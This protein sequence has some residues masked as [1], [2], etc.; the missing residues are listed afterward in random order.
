MLC[1]IYECE[2]QDRAWGHRKDAVHKVV[3]RVTN[4]QCPS[5]WGGGAGGK[6]HMQTIWI[7]KNP[8]L[9]K[10]RDEKIL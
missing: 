1:V 8:K 4:W 7:L 2:N 9:K 5:A 10:K 3:A 6:G